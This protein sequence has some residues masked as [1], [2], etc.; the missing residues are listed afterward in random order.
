MTYRYIKI[1][2]VAACLALCGF[3][4]YWIFL[5][6]VDFRSPDFLKASKGTISGTCVEA[7]STAQLQSAW[8]HRNDWKCDTASQQQLSDLLAMRCTAL[9]PA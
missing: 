3:D 4:I 1:A 9:E 2:A 5:A 7:A 6:Y 8:Y